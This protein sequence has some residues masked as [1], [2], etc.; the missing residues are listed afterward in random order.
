MHF[1]IF[2]WLSLYSFRNL[3]IMFNFVALYLEN[4]TY[5][6]SVMGIY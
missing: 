2:K 1:L 3:L 4:V 5:L 6:M